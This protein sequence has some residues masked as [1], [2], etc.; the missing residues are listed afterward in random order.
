MVSAI[1]G[2]YDDVINPATELVIGRVPRGTAADVERAVAA[3]AGA[4][5]AWGRTTPAVRAMALLALADLLDEH[6]TELAELEA[7]NV[8]KPRGAAADEL[9]LC[10]DHLRFFAGA[11]L[12]EGKASGEYL[13]GYTS[14][15]RHEPVGVVGQITPWNYPLCMAIWKI[16]PAL[17]AGNTIVLKPSELTPLTTIR[18]ADLAQTVLPPGVFNVI[19]GHGDPVGTGIVTHPAVKMISLTG[20]VGTGKAIARAAADTLARV[21]LELGGKA[22]V[23]VLDD[24]DVDAVVANL[25]VSSF[26]NAGQDCTAAC[27][28]IATVGERGFF[29]SP[30][31]V[32]APAQDSEIVQQE[33]FGPGRLRATRR[34]RRRSAR[35]GQRHRLRAVVVD[36]DQRRAPGPALHAR[37]RLRSRVGQRPHAVL[38]GDAARGLRRLGLRQGPLGLLA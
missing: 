15:I 38:V 29:I 11:G 18:L 13:E 32:A 23:V 10:S 7:L 8:G 21:H 30:A 34:R 16:G 26:F 17:A 24:A 1:D 31:V 20:S 14:T 25:R 36:L 27:H 5:R 3:A 33:L 6:A 35:L 4:A 9:P 28:V 19:T 37:A 22:P 12:L 2:A